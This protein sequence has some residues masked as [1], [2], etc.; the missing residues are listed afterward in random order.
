MLTLHPAE[1]PL[2]G[3]IR[4]PG[5]KSISHRSIILGAIAK[6]DTEVTGFL[7]SADSRATISAFEKMGVRIEG[8]LDKHARP[9]LRVHGKGLYGLSQPSSAIDALNSGT[10][11]RLLAGLLSAQA[12]TSSITG[13]ESL[14]RRPMKRVITP[15]T[16]M[17]AQIETL[18]RPDCLPM[19]IHGARLTG[20]DYTSPQAS[21]QVKSALLLAGLYADTPTVIREP[22]LSRN[23]SEIMLRSFGADV[24][25]DI[26]AIDAYDT[27]DVFAGAV[28]TLRPGTQLKAQEVY[29]PG[30]ISSAAFFIAAALLLEGS[31][32]LLKN[33]GVNPSR[34]G[35]LK[36][37]S[38]MGADIEAVEVYEESAEPC[39]DLLVRH[40][41]LS[42]PG[43][44][45]IVGG[46]DIPTLIDELPMLA[47]LS[48]FVEGTCVIKD[49][50][51]L[52]VKESDRIRIVVDNLRAMGA[53]VTETEDGMIIRGGA[54]LHGAQIKT[55]GD[56]RIAM[57]FAIA[58][59]AVSGE[60]IIDDAEC[61]NVSYPGFFRDLSKIA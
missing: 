28:I 49:A 42:I 20:I 45:L 31:E 19:R 14:R 57:G 11:A 30:D 9:H 23:H 5:D 26:E 2:S 52:K 48:A 1:R 40:A 60:T 32:I 61:I 8:S 56:H 36:V 59:L 6:G 24:T 33:V 21:A 44:M 17:G 18:A 3:T 4:I 13:D 47:I 34:A 51:E 38:R 41:P 16:Q 15:L 58:S 12:F 10:T 46:E 22:F 54:P 43:D 27:P 29:V 53:D 7:E 39:A 37:L 50:Q 25:G 55:H 35:F